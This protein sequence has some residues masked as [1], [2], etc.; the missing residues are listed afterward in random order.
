MTSEES[1]YFN[2]V[3]GD[4][5]DYGV[6]PVTAERTAN[7]D[8]GPALTFY[9]NTGRIEPQEAGALSHANRV[10][11]QPN[12]IKQVGHW[13]CRKSPVAMHFP[14]LKSKQL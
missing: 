10:L 7:R 6:Q 4:S 5:G 12:W 1:L 2:G 11:T 3:N 9:R 14:R 13:S 8:C